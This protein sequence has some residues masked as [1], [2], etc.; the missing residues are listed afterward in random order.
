MTDTHPINRVAWSPPTDDE[1][2]WFRPPPGLFPAQPRPLE[3]TLAVQAFVFGLSR[4]L[5]SLYFPLYEVRARLFDRELYLAAAPSAMAEA[6]LDAQLQRLRDS[7]LRFSRD[8]R[9]AWERTIR[10]EVEEYNER[11]AAF[12]PAD[13]D[14]VDIANQLPGL[15]RVRAN[16][17]FAPIRAVIAPTVLL[18]E[19]GVGQTPPDVAMAVVAEVRDIVVGRGTAEF[20]SAVSRFGEHLVHSDALTSRDFIWWLDY[21]DVLGSLTH[22]PSYQPPPER[23]VPSSSAA[24]TTPPETIGPPLPADAPRMYLLREVLDLI[25]GSLHA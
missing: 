8:I 5:E 22:G 11:F 10:A 17:W 9:A 15:K 6:D 13:A 25:A 3:Y 2:T 24:R 14:A 19:Q 12:A 1:L 20:E 16:Q 18:L 4:A 23:L 21:Q 7:A